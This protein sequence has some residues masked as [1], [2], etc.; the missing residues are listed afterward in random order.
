MTYRTF[1]NDIVRMNNTYELPTI[2]AT[3]WLAQIERIEKFHSIL[4]EECNEIIDIREKLNEAG[5]DNATVVLAE[6]KVMLADLLGDLIVYCASEAERWNIP[7]ADVLKIIMSS[8]FS[9]LDENGRPIKDNRGKFLKGPNYWKPEPAIKALLE[10][11]SVL[12]PDTPNVPLD[13]DEVA[14]LAAAQMKVSGTVP[15]TLS[16]ADATPVSTS[17]SDLGDSDNHP[18]PL[19]PS[20]R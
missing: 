7:L 3:S 1:T 17:H 11:Q 16:Q 10:G 9:K 19:P 4:L 8:N 18:A 14:A 13:M 5:D 20:T 15:P 2:P 6:A 12:L